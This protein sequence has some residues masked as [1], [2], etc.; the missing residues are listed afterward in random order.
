MLYT[1]L[2]QFGGRIL[3]DDGWAAFNSDAGVR[4]LQYWQSLMDEDLVYPGSLEMSEQ[5]MYEMMAGE[6]VSLFLIGPWVLSIA[7]MSNPDINLAFSPLWQEPLCTL[8]HSRKYRSC[9]A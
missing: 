7:R 9:R 3:N 1:P 4:A 8:R 6:E 5:M 2:I